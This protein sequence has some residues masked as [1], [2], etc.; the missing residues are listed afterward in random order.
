MAHVDRQRILIQR[1]HIMSEEF[2]KAVGDSRS[3]IQGFMSAQFLYRP[4]LQ[5]PRIHSHLRSYVSSLVISPAFAMPRT[6][7]LLSYPAIHGARHWGIFIPHAEDLKIGKEIHVV[8]S[9]FRGYT[10]E[11]KR[12]Y[13]PSKTNRK[14]ELTPLGLVQDDCV[15]NVNEGGTL[16]LDTIAQDTLEMEAKTIPAI[17]VSKNPLDPAVSFLGLINVQIV[18]TNHTG[19]ELP[20]VAVE[21]S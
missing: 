4:F 16:S 12:N 6:I 18:L 9:P 3:C 8:G 1:L 7:F 11:F 14:V 15:V 2:A 17:G 5:S 13:D 19:R 10:L 21:I 20:N